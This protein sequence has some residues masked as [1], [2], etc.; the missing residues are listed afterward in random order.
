MPTTLRSTHPPQTHKITL[1]N[2][3]PNN[4]ATKQQVENVLFNKIQV[5]ITS[6]SKISNGYLI[7][8]DITEHVDKIVA[9]KQ[10]FTPLSLTPKL[11]KTILAQQTLVIRFVDESVTAH[12]EDEIKTEITQHQNN[13]SPKIDSIVKLPGKTR[14][15]KI[16][17]K[18]QKTKEQFTQSGLFLFNYRVTP[19]Q[20][21]QEEFVPIQ[22]CFRC[23]Q[24]EDHST[25]ECTTDTEHCSNCADTGHTYQD[26]ANNTE[27][28]VNCKRQNLPFDHHTLA[29]RCPVRKEI[30][31]Q[32]T[33]ESR[34]RNPPPQ[35]PEP[36]SVQ[37]NTR[38]NTPT[39][40]PTLDEST[41]LRIT[42]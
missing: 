35:T 20:V 5:S 25:D 13:N 15:F 34:T 3:K 33:Q 30:V 24:H 19:S 42:T 14:T 27:G 23:Y 10:H 8:T 18:E 39:P 40:A 37:P 38:N 11:P 31:R 12:T 21:V 28:C 22:T 1:I 4:T 26:C 2:T 29:Y 17:C 16:V 9:G 6:L 41:I 32:K 7:R 36:T